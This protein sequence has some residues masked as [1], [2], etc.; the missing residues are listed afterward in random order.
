MRTDNLRIPNFSSIDN[1][2]QLLCEMVDWNKR[3]DK[4]YF[5]KNE[6]AEIGIRTGKFVYKSKSGEEAINELYNTNGKDTNNGVLQNAKFAMNILRW[7]GLISTDFDRE[8]YSITSYGFIIADKYYE[9]E[10]DNKLLLELFMNINSSNENI[11]KDTCNAIRF[12]N[13]I[14]YSICYA[15]HELNYCLTKTEME[16]LFRFQTKEI[17]AFV[18]IAQNSRRESRELPSYCKLKTQRGTYVAN[19]SNYTRMT[20]QILKK[21]DIIEY[22]MVKKDIYND[23]NNLQNCYVCTENGKKYVDDIFKNWKRYKF[24]TSQEFRTL[25]FVNRKEL[26][27]LGH[28]NTLIKS[29]ILQYADKQEEKN[30]FKIFS[31]IHSIPEYEYSF[32]TDSEMKPYPE[33]DRFVN[34]NGMYIKESTVSY[35]TLRQNAKVIRLEERSISEKLYK[36]IESRKDNIEQYIQELLEY[37]KKTTKEEFYPFTMSLFEI[38]GFRVKIEQGRYD[39]IAY[40]TEISIPI[41]IKSYTEVKSYNIKSIQQAAENRI[42]MN[43]SENSEFN[44]SHDNCSIV[45]GYSAPE[46]G[47]QIETLID[48]FYK[49]FSIKIMAIDIECLLRYAVD[50]VIK[51]IN[52]DLNELASMKGVLKYE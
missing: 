10:N 27:I 41:E 33:F 15:L 6:V 35:N 42:R 17:E 36:D 11:E 32:Y 28:K 19:P 52:Y 18:K 20:N 43:A 4:C 9:D 38:I 44:T 7:L 5:T 31:P 12:S 50:V 40:N 34:K 46:Q 14:G 45:V 29:G 23:S 47:N 39:G 24:I 49:S 1:L 48:A 25:P 26:V 16:A 37:H 51:G 13:Y 2:I 3:E 30:K 22:K 8:I 21:C